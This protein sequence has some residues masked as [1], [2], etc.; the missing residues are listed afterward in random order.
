MYA[1]SLAV[2]ALR[3]LTFRAAFARCVGSLTPVFLLFI[4]LVLRFSMFDIL[5]GEKHPPNFMCKLKQ[6]AAEHRK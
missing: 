5:S 6:R 1:L 4:F 2:T 3:R